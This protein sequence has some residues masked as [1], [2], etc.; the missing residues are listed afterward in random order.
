M[1]TL[2]LK[3]FKMENL[4]LTVSYVGYQKQVIEIKVN[5]NSVLLPSILS[6]FQII[7]V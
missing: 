4:L 5:S 7:L 1:A 3:I 6:S 2:C